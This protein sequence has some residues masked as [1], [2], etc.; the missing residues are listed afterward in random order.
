MEKRNKCIDLDMCIQ[1]IS[2][3]DHNALELLYKEL[4]NPIYR[5]SLMI[6]KDAH[7]A[8]DAMQNTFMKIMANAGL[9]RPGT[10]PRSWVFSIARNVCM[11]LYK[12]KSPVVEESVL[13][14]LSDNY[15]IEDLA[16]II[17]V[18]EAIDKLTITEKEILSLYIF[19]GLKQTEI[20]KVMNLPYVKVRSH[21]K[22]AIQKIRKELGE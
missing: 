14:S 22:Y 19:A 1:M 10:K 16:D 13:N 3:Q 21:Y 6:L 5:F 12:Q 20:S 7:L 4:A 15:S 17:S 2:R 9:Y 8:E 18:R 11:D